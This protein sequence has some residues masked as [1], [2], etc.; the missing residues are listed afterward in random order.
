ML[1]KQCSRIGPHIEARGKS[2]GF[3]HVAEGTWDIF[4]SYCR[5]DPSNL[6]F[7]QR[8]QDS[9]L[10]TRD[11]SGI[12]SRIGRAIHMLLKVKQKTQCPFLVATMILGFL[13]IFKKSQASSPFEALN[14]TPLEVSKGCEASCTDEAGTSG[15]L[16]GL[17]R[18]FRY[19]FIL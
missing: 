2:H 19:P 16:L 7:V 18:G 12:S 9:C 4:S 11:T 13:S 1:C 10:V 8:C 3:I 15:F 5:D 17:H 6:V 14:S